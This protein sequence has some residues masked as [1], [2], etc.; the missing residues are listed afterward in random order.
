MFQLFPG[1]SLSQKLQKLTKSYKKELRHVFQCRNLIPRKCPRK[2]PFQLTVGG[3]GNHPFWFL[4]HCK[5]E[6]RAK[7]RGRHNQKKSKQTLVYK[8]ESIQCF[9]LKLSVLKYFFCRG[10]LF[11]K[12]IFHDITLHARCFCSQFYLCLLMSVRS[13]SF[14]LDGSS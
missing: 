3:G 11:S 1:I 13:W 7:K 6:H 14:L 10:L 4:R 2:P 12:G 8:L 5:A 9:W